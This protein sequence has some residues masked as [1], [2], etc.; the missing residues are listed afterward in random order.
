[1]KKTFFAL[2]ISLFLVL[3]AT[4]YAEAESPH[5]V[6]SSVRWL[7]KHGY[8]V[9]AS[10]GIA[11]VGSVYLARTGVALE[12]LGASF[13]VGGATFVLRA[14]AVIMSSLGGCRLDDTYA[15]PFGSDECR[16]FVYTQEEQQRA[17]EID[18]VERYFYGTKPDVQ[19]I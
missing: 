5:T 19:G 10:L 8:K 18:P 12:F 6:P 16:P 15:L 11:A 7:V 13:A 1:M 9:S 17:P 14:L 4:S 2:A 3:P